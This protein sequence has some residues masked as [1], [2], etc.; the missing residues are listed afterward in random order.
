MIITSH[1]FSQKA[2]TYILEIAM[3]EAGKKKANL[4]HQ[5]SQSNQATMIY[6]DRRVCCSLL[7][8]SPGKKKKKSIEKKTRLEAQN[9]EQARLGRPLL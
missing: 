1:F 2:P 4:P 7:S 5:K 6:K 3:S 8:A 9:R